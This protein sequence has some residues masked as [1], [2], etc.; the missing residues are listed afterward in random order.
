LGAP[1]CWRPRGA[2]FGRPDEKGNRVSEDKQSARHGTLRLIRDLADALA[3]QAERYK[4]LASDSGAGKPQVKQIDTLVEQARG[5]KEQ[6]H[7]LGQAPTDT[8]I[9][10]S[11][12]DAPASARVVPLK[13]DAPGRGRSRGS[14]SPSGVTGAAH[15]L[16]IEMKIEGRSRADVEQMLAETF[17]LSNVSD[18]VDK[19][20]SGSGSQ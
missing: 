9:E 12:A 1:V 6:A 2:W 10:Q 13:A 3:T 4:R 5:V 14:A 19:V 18:I 17:G 8:E 11:G 7:K 16:A 15:T 20:F